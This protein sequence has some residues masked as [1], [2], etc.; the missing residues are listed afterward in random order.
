MSNGKVIA[1]A[2]AIVCGCIC[3]YLLIA[4]LLNPLVP[5]R[6]STVPAGGAVRIRGAPMAGVR[7][8]YHP[9]FK[10]GKITLNPNGVTDS[11]G[12]FTLSCDKPGNGAPA[13]DYIVTFDFPY[14]TSDG[15]EEEIDLF[16]GKYSN[17][18][19]SQWKVTVRR[20]SQETFQL[21]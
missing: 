14:V 10:M 12:K 19:T 17:P 7:V 1:T 6:I 9:Q 11:E 16:E 15:I 2:A 3:V 8:T 5:I 4:Y 13:G 20:D 21:D 18:I